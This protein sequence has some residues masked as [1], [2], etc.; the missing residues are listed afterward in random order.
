MPRADR[1][2]ASAIPTPIP[3]VSPTLKPPPFLW[4][5]FP[6]RPGVETVDE[7]LLVDVGGDDEVVLLEAFADDDMEAEAWLGGAGPGE[8]GPGAMLV[9]DDGLGAGVAAG[10]PGKLEDRSSSSSSVSISVS[11]GSSTVGI[12]GL[13]ISM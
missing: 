12:V 7:F 8:A 9:V 5:G 3:A 2:T 11:V 1:I 13:A 6:G 4:V 10:T